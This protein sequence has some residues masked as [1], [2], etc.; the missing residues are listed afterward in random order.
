MKEPPYPSGSVGKISLTP[1]MS[2]PDWKCPSKIPFQE[3]T[4]CTQNLRSCWTGRSY[5]FKQGQDP[6]FWWQPQHLPTFLLTRRSIF[7]LNFEANTF[8]VFIHI[9]MWGLYTKNNKDPTWIWGADFSRTGWRIASLDHPKIWP[10]CTIIMHWKSQFISS[11]HSFLVESF[12]LKIM[13][14]LNSTHHFCAYPGMS[15]CSKTF[16]FPRWGKEEPWRTCPKSWQAIQG[17]SRGEE[18]PG[19]NA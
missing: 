4:F 9:L 13:F 14:S 19:G 2:T 5:P 15:R 3:K 17:I 16:L 12:K 7:Q 8:H 10:D 11:K 1:E 6:E 18:W